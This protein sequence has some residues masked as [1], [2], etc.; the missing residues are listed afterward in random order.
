MSSGRDSAPPAGGE[1]GEILRRPADIARRADR[2]ELA[3]Q[4]VVELEQALE[5]LHV[6]PFVLLGDIAEEAV[7]GC[8]RDTGRRDR[9]E[10]LVDQADARREGQHRADPRCP[11]AVRARDE[12]RS[13]HGYAAG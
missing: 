7:E 2:R 9:A 4:A 5:R 11:R 3:A 6:R 13:L 8:A 1:V 10:R 12:D